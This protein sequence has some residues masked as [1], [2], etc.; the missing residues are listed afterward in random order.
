MSDVKSKTES[1]TELHPLAGKTGIV[2]YLN[3]TA[4]TAVYIGLG[5]LLHPDPNT[6]PLIGIPI[7]ILF[8]V[9]IARRPLKEL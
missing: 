3:V 9:F 6:Y 2:H 4:A 1:P 5:F 7:T 8:Q